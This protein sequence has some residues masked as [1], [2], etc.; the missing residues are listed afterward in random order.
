ML[1][2]LI[3]RIPQLMQ[4]RL[5]MLCRLALEAHQAREKAVVRVPLAQ[6]GQMGQ[7]GFRAPMVVMALMG[8]VV[9]RGQAL[10]VRLVHMAA[11]VLRG[12]TELMVRQAHQEQMAAPVLPGHPAPLALERL[13]VMA[14]R[15][16]AVLLVHRGQ[17]VLAFQPA[18]QPASFWLKL[19]RRIITHNKQRLLQAPVERG[20]V[21][22]AHPVLQG[23]RVMVRQE[24]PERL[25]LALMVL[26][27]PPEHQAH[28]GLVSPVHPAQ[29]AL[30]G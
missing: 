20:L 30:Q 16:Q 10:L 29:V 17:M 15:E 19:T 22:Q 7:Q 5:I 12:L 21:L 8:Q 27:V 28:Q 13:E 11:T 9:P 6:V 3:T 23:L 25:G 26:M 4:A 1:E 18:V 24:P 2:H 14:L